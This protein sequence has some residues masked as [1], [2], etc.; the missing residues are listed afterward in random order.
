MIITAID[1]NISDHPEFVSGR[2]VVGVRFED[3]VLDK[4][5]QRVTLPNGV[6]LGLRLDH[7]HPILREGDVLSADENSVY[8]V[9]IIP[10]DVLVITPDDIH[11]MG[12]V[13]HSL[14]NRHLPAQFAKPGEVTDKAAMIVQYDHTVVSFL[15]EHEVDYQRT[16]LV[17][18]IPFRHSGHTH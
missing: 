15:D 12:F 2:E 6:E 8:V 3:L 7:G 17:P 16:E 9:E 18:P 13:A 11:Q 14:G 10:T 4:R 1:T 5:I